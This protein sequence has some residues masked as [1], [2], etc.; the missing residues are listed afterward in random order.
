LYLENTFG[1]VRALKKTGWK[2]A[3]TKRSSVRHEAM[4]FLRRRPEI[5]RPSVKNRGRT[6]MNIVKKKMKGNTTR[7]AG[8]GKREEGA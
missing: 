4:D 1:T 8:A 6:V 7:R 5:P 3:L 2:I